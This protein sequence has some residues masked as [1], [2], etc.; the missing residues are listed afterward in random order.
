MLKV[1]SSAK[2]FRL[3]ERTFAYEGVMHARYLDEERKS[4]KNPQ[5]AA[6]SFYSPV[7]QRVKLTQSGGQVATVESSAPSYLQERIKQ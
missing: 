2:F 6:Q 5:P 7:A 1:D 3:A 4:K